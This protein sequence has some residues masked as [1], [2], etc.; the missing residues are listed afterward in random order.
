MST[1]RL[2]VLLVVIASSARAEPGEAAALDHLDRGV[3]AY[4][5][6]D[7]D[8][9]HREL[10]LAQGLAPD[11]P[12]PYRWLALTEVKQ[13]HCREAIVHIEAF[14]SRVPIGDARVPELVALRQECL[15][16]AQVATPVPAL[17]PVAPPVYRR[18]WFWTAIGAVALAAVGITIGVT[19]D[20]GSRLPA[21][22]CSPAGCP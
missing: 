4:R 12:N 9:A 13:D 7:Y 14:L 20:D 3:A 8:A 2:A 10:E 1:L 15:R 19:H 18:W 11:R 5:L 22:H 6:G 17:P 21:I 16:T